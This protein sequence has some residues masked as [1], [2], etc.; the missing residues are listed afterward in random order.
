M[1]RD[2]DINENEQWKLE[3]HCDKCR[4]LKYCSKECTVRRNR[5]DK[6]VRDFVAEK[7]LSKI[8]KG[9]MKGGF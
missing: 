2:E 8:F 3:G 5:I 4:R 7:T 9:A 6:E 1:N